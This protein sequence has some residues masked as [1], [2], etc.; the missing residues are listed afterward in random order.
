MEENINFKLRT[1]IIKEIPDLKKCFQ[2]GT[3]VS[4]CPAKIYSGHFSPREFILKCLHGLQK[5]VINDDLW[6]CITCHSCNE[7]CPQDVNPYEVIVKMKNIAVRD[8]LISE[9]K[10]QEV[11]SAFNHL[12]DTGCPYP[13]NELTQ[14]KREELGLKPIKTNHI[15]ICDKKE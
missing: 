15:K 6:R 3:C 11:K 5:E 2:C 13:V 1:K 4:S 9:E 10:M 12:I 14:K 7:R 8:G